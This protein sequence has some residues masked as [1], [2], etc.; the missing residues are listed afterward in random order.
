M[1]L[2]FVFAFLVCVIAAGSAWAFNRPSVIADTKLISSAECCESGCC[3][4]SK[5]SSCCDAG[6]CSPCDESCCCATGDCG[7]DGSC[8]AAASA[9]TG[10]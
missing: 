8:C 6:C 4:L 3:S 10:L 9:Q 2:K 7:C 5:Q 1:S